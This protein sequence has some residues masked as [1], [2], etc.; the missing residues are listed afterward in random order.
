MSFVLLLKS[1]RSRR[2]SP[3]SSS[4][5]KCDG[6]DCSYEEQQ[7]LAKLRQVLEERLEDY[8]MEPKL[9]SMQLV[10][11]KVLLEFFVHPMMAQ[12]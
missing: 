6:F 5:P 4:P 1:G 3:T 10:L 11:F 12:S 9:V 8:N 7:S 2:R